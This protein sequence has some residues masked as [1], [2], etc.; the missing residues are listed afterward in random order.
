VNPN[1]TLVRCA[2]LFVFGCSL[3]IPCT[4]RAQAPDPRLERM[5]AD[6]K[7]R[8]EDFK[9]VRYE[10]DGARVTARGSGTDSMGR[11]VKPE[12]PPRDISCPVHWVFLIDFTTGRYRREVNEVLYEVGTGK[13]YPRITLDA[14]DGSLIRGAMPRQANTTKN[15]T[16]SPSAPDVVT[17]SGNL[18]AVPFQSE[19]L[20]IFFGHGIIR[21]MGHEIFAGGFANQP[22][23]ANFHIHGNAVHS[24]RSCVVIRNQALKLSTTSY[25]EYWVDTGR[26]SSIVR[27]VEY[28]GGKVFN[29]I[30]ID[31]KDVR[32][33]WL[34]ARWVFTHYNL[35]RTS[36]L[37]RMT[38]EVKIDPDFSDADF[39]FDASPGMLVEESHYGDSPNPL[40]TPEA[41]RKFYTIN[42]SG[43]KTEIID[44]ETV[45][46]WPVWK[47]AIPVAFLVISFCWLGF[48]RYKRAKR[49]A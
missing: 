35:G 27:Y 42:E 36:F 29:D 15:F 16:P 2:W 1:R 37:D 45:K 34:P 9:S 39:K 24:G 11:P 32:N 41:Q 46:A 6:W 31:Y 30:S 5:F 26:K 8:Q 10:I 20:P 48:R 23:I 44:G 13:S 18:R 12:K 4:A 33:H 14:F 7:E 21:T 49:M 28:S 47:W 17:I 40:V 43:I 19:Y 25:D 38:A 3:Y 22:D